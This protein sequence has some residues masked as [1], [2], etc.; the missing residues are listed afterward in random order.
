MR[1]GGG[2]GVYPSRT[3]PPRRK[4]R[5]HPPKQNDLVK[6]HIKGGI[7]WHRRPYTVERQRVQL[8]APK[9][10]AID[11]LTGLYSPSM[12]IVPGGASRLSEVGKL[13]SEADTLMYQNKHSKKVSRELPKPFGRHSEKEAS[14]VLSWYSLSCIEQK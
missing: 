14:K 2:F 1:L 9:L 7:P 4:T 5:R 3:Q 13:L 10:A 12:G 11:D 6:G 8:Q